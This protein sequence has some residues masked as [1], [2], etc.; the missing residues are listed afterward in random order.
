MQEDVKGLL[1]IIDSRLKETDE[2]NKN[3]HSL[4]A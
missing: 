3:K 4:S 2:S 1:K